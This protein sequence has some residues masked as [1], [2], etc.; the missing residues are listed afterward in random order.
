MRYAISGF[1]VAAMVIGGGCA[2]MHKEKEAKKL[3]PSDVPPKVMSAMDTRFQGAQYTSITREEEQGNTIYDFELTQGG[4][5]YEADVKEDGT[6]MEI[7]KA[8]EKRDLPAPVSEA[9]NKKY[10]NATYNEVME[11]SLVNG[12]QETPHEY[13]VVLR[14]AKG[15]EQEVTVSTDGKIVHD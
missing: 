9:L 8:I 2:A 11:K 5:K 4:R 13:E 12:K 3:M 15:K 7:E 1:I 14:T 10:P 6:I